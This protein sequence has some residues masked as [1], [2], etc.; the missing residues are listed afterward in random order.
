VIL[1]DSHVLLWMLIQP[2][3]LSSRAVAAIRTA[4]ADQQDLAVSVVSIYELARAIARGRVST[5]IA[6]EDFL[7]RA[8]A[9]VTILPI[10]PDIAIAAAQLPADFPSDPFDRIIAATAMAHRAALITADDR[11]RRSRALRTIW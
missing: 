10:V 3:L 8:E 2:E 1:L 6:P 7:R 4:L 11:I 9:Y 5:V